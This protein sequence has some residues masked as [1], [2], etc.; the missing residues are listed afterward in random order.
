MGAGGSL[1]GC[2]S[3]VDSGIGG[4]LKCR[5][6]TRGGQVDFVLTWPGVSLSFEGLQLQKWP[7]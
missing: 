6:G 4:G 2:S 1:D 3:M 7:G 5:S